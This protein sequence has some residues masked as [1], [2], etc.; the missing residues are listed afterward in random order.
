MGGKTEEGE[1]KKLDELWQDEE[2]EVG[3]SS[4][5]SR[6]SVLF[7]QLPGCI[8]IVQLSPERKVEEPVFTNAKEDLSFCSAI[9]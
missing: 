8:L 5:L 1:R 4:E 6:L 9:L 2:E 7:L 3:E